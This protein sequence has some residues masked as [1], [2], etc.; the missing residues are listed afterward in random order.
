MDTIDE[1]I[2]NK[3][4]NY[5][6]EFSPPRNGKLHLLQAARLCTPGSGSGAHFARKKPVKKREVEA[7][8]IYVLVFPPVDIPN[9]NTFQWGVTNIRF[10]M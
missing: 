1:Y 3:L 4:K 10:V 5:S 9:L 2:G 7:G 8:S 6:N